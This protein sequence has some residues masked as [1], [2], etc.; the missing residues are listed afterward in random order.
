M[1]KCWSAALS[2]EITVPAMV[3]EYLHLILRESLT[4]ADSHVA[5]DVADGAHARDDGRDG[6]MAQDVAECYLGYLVLA[7]PELGDDDPHAVVDLLLA[8]AAEVVV[9]EISPFESGIRG[10]PT[11][12]G[13]LVEGY[14]D[15]HADV[16]LLA[17]WKEPV[18]RTLI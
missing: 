14:P 15:Y 10:D 16:V 8:F 6:R 5:L 3:L 2:I 1:L 17:S 9:A 7:R 4:V 13:A 11:R 18:L 12:Q